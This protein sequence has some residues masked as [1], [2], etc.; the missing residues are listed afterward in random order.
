MLY[1]Y[2]KLA[3]RLLTRNPSFTAVN[4]G[5]LAVGFASFFALWSYSISELKSNQYL[6]DSDRI[7]RIGTYWQWTD[8]GGKTRAH[9]T[10]GFTKADLAARFQDDFPEVADKTRILQQSFFRPDMVPHDKQITLSTVGKIP[11]ERVFKEDKVI[12]AD[13]NLFRMFSLPLIYGIADNVLREAGS[14][15]L[16]ERLAKKYFDEANPLGELLRLNDSISLQVTGIFKNLP[17][18]THFDFEAAISNQPYLSEWEAAYFGAT[19]TYVKFRKGSSMQEFEKKVNQKTA[20]YFSKVLQTRPNVNPSLFVQPL[21]DIAFSK[22]Y[23]GDEFT[24]RSKTVLSAICFSSVVILGMA[25]CNYLNLWIARSAKREKELATRKVNGANGKDFFFQFITES[26]IINILSVVLAI[27]ILQLTKIPFQVLFNIH[28]DALWRIEALTGAM[29]LLA[30]ILSTLLTGL[31]PALV[32]IT[33]QPKELLQ[34]S[35]TPKP[36]ARLSSILAV[37]QYTSATIA[38]VWATIVCLELNHVLDG[39]MGFD[40]ENVMVIESPI[41][42]NDDFVSQLDVLSN[43]LLRQQPIKQVTYGKFMPGDNVGS[44]KQIRRL[45]T[46]NAVGVDYNGV[47]EA[48]VPFFGLRMVAGRNF[49]TD[50]RGDVVLVSRSAA[51]RLGFGDPESAVG[52]MLEA[53][54]GFQQRSWTPPVEII[55][56]FDDFRIASFFESAGNRTQY[57]NEHQSRGILLAYKNHLFPDFVPEKIALKVHPR[58]L[59]TMIVTARKE[60]QTVF[61]GEVFSWSFLDESINIVYQNEKI[62]RNQILLFMALAVTIA[63]LGF[64]GMIMHA[65]VSRTKEVGIRKILGASLSHIGRLILQSSLIQFL[66]ALALGLPIAAYMG[67]IYMQKFSAR[68]PLYW[69]HYASPVV[70]LAL[71]ML[72]TVITVVWKAAKTNPAQTLKR[73]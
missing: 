7:A 65:T 62:V 54:Q 67:E 29:F 23:E 45:G 44:G 43:R 51:T 22:S 59:D 70:L 20:E 12:Y 15:V 34:H 71:V 32:A 1:S 11:E 31:Y 48:F 14:V 39:D 73:E 42:K 55:G 50:D 61:P 19:Q 52:S 33:K 72:G 53:D 47:S 13:E 10:F 18:H 63:C 5:G 16:S 36:K 58:D 2:F 40:R 35:K 6:R 60:F 24:P 3:V 49:I 46:V 26:S 69:W 27:T 25:W 57:E 37:I 28:I 64:L 21:K 56:V 8:D 9:N 41:K 38:I 4:I 66:A 68:V 30:M 17:H